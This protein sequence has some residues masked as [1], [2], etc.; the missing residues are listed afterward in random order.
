MVSAAVLTTTIPYVPFSLS[1]EHANGRHILCFSPTP[2]LHREPIYRRGEGAQTTHFHALR[3]RGS[4]VHE[5]YFQLHGDVLPI[6]VC[7]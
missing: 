1:G 3:Y 6:V 2:L 4:E 7:R 5:L